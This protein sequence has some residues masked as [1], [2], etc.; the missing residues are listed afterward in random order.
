[1]LITCQ[2]PKTVT[3]VGGASIPTAVIKGYE[4]KYTVTPPSP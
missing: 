2:M 4:V 1:M 3:P